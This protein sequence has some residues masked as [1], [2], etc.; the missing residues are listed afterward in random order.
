MKVKVFYDNL[1]HLSDQR[2]AYPTTQLFNKAVSELET[3]LKKPIE[4]YKAFKKDMVNYSLEAVKQAYPKPFNL[5]LDDSSTLKMLGIDLANITNIAD[6]IQHTPHRF[7]VCSKSGTAT[8]C[9]DKEPYTY[10]AETPEQ[11][12]RLEFANEIIKLAEKAHS[13]KPNLNKDT[14]VSGF[15]DF[16]VF[17]PSKGF[18]PNRFFVMQGIN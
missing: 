5:G 10:Y 7:N 17:E 16:A 4:D 3:I 6:K 12:E 14:I 8:V 11:L 2:D 13:L 15:Y 18:M 9:D 1:Q